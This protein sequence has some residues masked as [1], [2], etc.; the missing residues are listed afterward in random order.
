MNTTENKIQELKERQEKEL[1]MGGVKGEEKEST[2]SLILIVSG[3]L[4]CL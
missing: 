4:T 1:A 2:S 3:N